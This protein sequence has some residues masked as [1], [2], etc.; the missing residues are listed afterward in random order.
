MDVT[1]IVSLVAT[2]PLVREELT[3][4]QK[5]MGESGGLVAE[6]RDIGTTVFPD[7]EL[8]IFLT[9][10]TTERARRRMIDLQNQGFSKPDFDNLKQQINERDHMDKSRSISPLIKAKDAKE[11][12]TDG[13]NIE[14][15][16]E[17]IE[18]LF[19]EKVPEEVWPTP[20]N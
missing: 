18:Q 13:M 3:T 16:I 6:G 12:V 11:L 8:K 9:A 17:V 7:A 20:S 14:Q 2:Q 1:S 19:R 5:A 15:V 10:S 4:Q